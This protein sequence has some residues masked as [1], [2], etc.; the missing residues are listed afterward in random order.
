MSYSMTKTFQTVNRNCMR[1]LFKKLYYMEV[2]I[3][4][5]SFT[6]IAFTLSSILKDTE[7]Q[8][9]VKKRRQLAQFKI[10]R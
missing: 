8:S 5:L 4:V 7:Q 9:Y 10:F 1:T 6:H 2:D 3:L